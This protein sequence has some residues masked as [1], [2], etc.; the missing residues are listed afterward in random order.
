MVENKETQKFLINSLFALI[1]TLVYSFLV[2]R[3]PI[4]LGFTILNLFFL[5]VLIYRK[6][7]L[8]KSPQSIVFLCF[9][10]I[11][12][13]F[14]TLRDFGQ[15]F[16]VLSIFLLNSMLVLELQQPL[17]LRDLISAPLIVFAAGIKAIGSTFS[18]IQQL[19]MA[20]NSSNLKSTL[21]VTIIGLVLGIPILLLFLILFLNADPLFAHY[22]ENLMPKNF[23]INQVLISKILEYILVFGIF[24]A[25]LHNIKY[26]PSEFSLVKNLARFR[27]EIAIASVLVIL[28]TGSFLAVQLQYIFAT[29]SLLKEM[30]VML[31]EYTRKGYNELLIVSSLSL[32]LITI[33][34][35]RSSDSVRKNIQIVA[36]IFLVEVLLVLLSASRRVY[37]YQDAHGFTT[38]RLLGIFFSIWLAATVV[39]YFFHLFNKISNKF[40]LALTINFLTVLLLMNLF[41]VDY[42]IGVVNKPNL[43]F[44]VDYPYIATLST[45]A[46]P[47]W[48]EGLDLIEKK[49]GCESMDYNF[50]STLKWRGEQLSYQSQDN[51][52]HFGSWNLSRSIAMEFSQENQARINTAYA[53][54]AKCSRY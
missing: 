19:V 35:H 12:S 3:T 7:N 1:L 8:T 38:A 6:P 29:E 16:N 54:L 41:S 36:G 5:C 21:R 22:F 24:N 49:I 30:G 20:K 51:W 26:Q 42:L 44:G 15:V 17:S 27:L 40:I 10:L 32:G 14:L 43:G 4:G 18:N 13:L 33:L 34:I 48:S 23:S 28:L 37:L 31:S 52:H 45:D 11:F 9:S 25:S 50:I 53:S 39:I 2:S 47:G 46:S